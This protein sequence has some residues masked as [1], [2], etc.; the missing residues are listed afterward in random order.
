MVYRDR[1]ET[2][3]LQLFAH[4]ETL[5]EFSMISVIIF[6]VNIVSEQK[7]TVLIPLFLFFKIFIAL[8]SY[9]PPC[10]TAVPVSLERRQNCS[11]WF[12]TLYLMSA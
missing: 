4:P 5:G 6:E 12:A 2:Y 10:P 7:Q 9:S 1:L 8:N 11:L 3:L